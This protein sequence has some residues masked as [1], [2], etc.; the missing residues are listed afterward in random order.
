VIAVG[1][2]NFQAGS[3]VLRLRTLGKNG[4]PKL[5]TCGST[6]S[7]PKD[8]EDDNESND[9]S[10]STHG[11]GV[12]IAA[13]PETSQAMAREQSSGHNGQRRNTLGRKHSPSTASADQAA[14]E[15]A[16][17][18]QPEES[19]HQLGEK[20][21]EIRKEHE[22]ITKQMARDAESFDAQMAELIRERDEKKVTLEEKE[23]ASERL[24]KDAT[25]HERQ[26]RIAQNKKTQRE[27]VLDEKQAQKTKRQDDMK[28]W[29]DEIEDMKLEREAWRTKKENLLMEKEE[30]TSKLRE[31]LC[32]H[33]QTTNRLE[34]EIHVKGLQIKE[35]ELERQ[36][37]PGAQDDEDSRELDE[38]G[39]LEHITWENTE[40]NLLEQLNAS[41]LQLRELGNTIQQHQN[42]LT[43]L[44]ANTPIMYHA[45]SSGVDF[46]PTGAAGKAKSR[47]TRNRKS[48]TNTISSPITAFPI[49]NSPFPGSSMYNSLNNTASPTFAPGPYMDMNSELALVPL[50]EQMVGMS[51]EDIR[52]L[53]A[54][55]PLSPTATSLL[56]SNIFADDDPPSPGAESIG[57]FGPA[58]YGGMSFE[59]EPQSPHSS[60]QSAS[61]M[62]SPQNSAHNLAMYGVSG[63]DYAEENERRSLNSPRTDFG[64]IGSAAPAEQSSPHKGLRDLFTLNRARGKT[65]QEDGPAFGSLKHGQ[66]QSFPRSTDEPDTFANRH[67]RISFSASKGW[68]NFLQRGSSAVEASSQGN[69]P[70]PARNVGARKRRGFDI[71]NSSMDEN[72]SHSERNP[73]SPRPLSVASSD[74]PRPSTDSA[75]FGWAPAPD[76]LI[77]RNSPL[78]TNWSINAPQ[79]WSR[80]PSRRPSIQ[81]GS[82]TALTSGIASDDD[83][84]LPPS[85]PLAGQSSPPP[86]GVIGTRPPSSH[87]PVTP[88]LNPAAPA[89][90]GFF[91]SRSSN[92]DKD[93][94]KEKGKGKAKVVDAPTASDESAP[95][96]TT[97]SPSASRYSRDT[98]SIHTQNSIAESYDSLERTSSNTASDMANTGAATKE[99]ASSLRELLRRKGS[100]SKFSLSSFRIPGKKAAGSAANSD[101]NASTERDGS[102]DEF[103]EDQGL[104]RSVD[105]VT[106]SPMLGSNASGDLKPKEKETAKEGRMSMNWG[107]FGLKKGKGR[108][109]SE[110][111]RSESELT[112][113][114]EAA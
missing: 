9:D 24:K 40:K 52:H 60:S 49:A 111:E 54:G 96:T 17:A 20:F 72:S 79:T 112:T 6:S 56:P 50:S 2:N 5:E 35:L 12:E 80:N 100:S 36:K 69:A 45:N 53:T 1:P 113:E 33:Q 3:S 26:N 15:L 101:R 59:N 90:K 106:S 109:S 21:E 64:V 28:R 99:T 23:K 85:D 44:Q 88:K 104:G 57:S 114:D 82:T 107:R 61:L 102:F 39:R 91:I 58:L 37:L 51:E 8:D 14:R 10:Q 71:F 25:H 68:S 22:E 98:P 89:F 13:L 110:I 65:M 66:S 108:E 43:I 93:K 87:K 18:G 31:E 62:S 27:K 41:S 4:R 70:A 103:R 38:E 92:V 97:S 86:V 19:M 11:I 105:S 47:R 75:P 30:T 32:A 67:R 7:L 77:N 29:K 48:R 83:E 78:A 46:D 42:H 73:S 55:A 84:F 81:H 94:E 63:R 76:A 95:L 74:L 34:E 16:V